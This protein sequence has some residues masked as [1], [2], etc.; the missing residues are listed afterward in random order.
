M[1]EPIT[2]ACYSGKHLGKHERELL[3]FLVLPM[4][5]IPSLS[6]PDYPGRLLRDAPAVRLVSS[7]DP[8]RL[9]SGTCQAVTF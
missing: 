7:G 1:N 9:P 8:S 2:Y 4:S 3:A 6:P 5:L